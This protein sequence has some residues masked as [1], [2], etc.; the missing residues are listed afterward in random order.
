MGVCFKGRARAEAE[1][2]EEE[3][4]AAIDL[5]V[6][7]EEGVLGEQWDSGIAINETVD[8]SELGFRVDEMGVLHDL[9]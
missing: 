9:P 8:L 6:E 1:E 7:A 4:A 2:E 3:A 5:E